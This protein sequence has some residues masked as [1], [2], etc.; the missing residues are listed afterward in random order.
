MYNLANEALRLS[1]WVPADFVFSARVQ[2]NRRAFNE[3][4][5]NQESFCLVTPKTTTKETRK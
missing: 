3:I 2:S 1:V 4:V 5:A